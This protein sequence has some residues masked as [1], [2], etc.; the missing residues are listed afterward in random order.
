VKKYALMLLSLFIG[1]FLMQGFQCASPEY[2]TAK[3]A[4]K[5]K[6]YT[7]A[8]EYF[9]KELKKNQQN[10]EAWMFMAE[11]KLYLRKLVESNEAADNAIKYAGKDLKIQMQAVNLKSKLWRDTYSAVINN[12]NRY[13]KTKNDT[14]LDIALKYSD[15][16]IQIA[17]YIYEFL[18]LKGYLY[19]L[20]NDM[21]NA[22][23][24]YEEYY[25]A[26]L[27]N[28]EFAKKKNIY[29]DI[30]RN[31]V[32]ISLGEPIASRGGREPRG[33]SSIVD[34]FK[35]DGKELFLKSVQTDV[36]FKTKTWRYNPPVNMTD[37]DKMILFDLATDPM[38]ELIQHYYDNK[39]YEKAME[40]LNSLLVLKPDNEQIN[41]FMITLYDAMGKKDEATKR[42]EQLI[43]S[44]PNNKS[45]RLSYGNLLMQLNRYDDAVIQ[46]EKALELDPKYY[47]ALRNLAS[48]YKNK[49]YVIQKRQ[50]EE[51]KG[52]KSKM[53]PDEYLPFIQKSGENFEKCRKT[54]K[55]AND[56]NILFDLVDIYF[57]TKQT[58]K[59]KQAVKEL[60]AMEAVVGKDD[61]E[62]YYLNMFKI[63][64]QR[65]PDEKK[66]EVYEKK[67]ENLNKK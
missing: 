28:I 23:N 65:L 4:L 43:K 48:A 30:P 12:M 21:T 20:K 9:E 56:V 19:Q 26:I 45:F 15:I 34:I 58:D 14:A 41:N 27:T 6:E 57:V 32:L 35:V 24:T 10:A 55:Y 39:Q 49:A 54:P 36:P 8:E 46:Y 17:P 62:N 33:D 38:V 61:K 22:I 67:I 11:T 66:S 42:M 5:N 2:T 29:M 63:F 59:M 40:V 1:A 52:D 31:A 7:K 47:D 44:D 18:N 3:L 53:N 51:A 50:L 13:F 60:E 37:I 64:Q 16:G 25:K